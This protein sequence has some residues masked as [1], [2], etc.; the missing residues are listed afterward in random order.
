MILRYLI[1]M[2]LPFIFY[3][4]LILKN[5]KNDFVKNLYYF[6]K[7]VEISICNFEFKDI[8]LIF[9]LL[10]LL[11]IIEFFSLQTPNKDFLDSLHDGDFLTPGLNY[12]LTNQFWQ[13]SFTVHGGSNIF[14]TLI[15]WKLLGAQTI[16]AYELFMSLLTLTLK[17]FSIIFIFYILKFTKLET[18]FKILFFTILSLI[19]L[20]FS[21]YNA[22]NY[23]S[24]RD[25]YVFIFFIYFI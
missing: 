24:I 23:L 2:G 17:M 10:F 22:T 25:L 21:S 15:S 14:Y 6:T 7:K 4:F 3:F 18:N 5:N 12:L 13:S 19:V 8:K 9:L 20:T 16:G 1:F 11:V